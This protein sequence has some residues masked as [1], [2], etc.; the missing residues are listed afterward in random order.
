MDNRYAIETDNVTRKFGDLVAVD[1]VNLK[2]NYGEIFGL[3][4]P[5]GAGKTT[6]THMLATILCPTTGTATVVGS[7][8]CKE[9]DKVRSAIGIVFQETSLDNNLTGRENLDFHG[10]MY[11]INSE[12]RKKRISEVLEIVGLANRADSLVK[13]YSGGMKR[14]LEI[15]RGLMHHPKIL[16]LDEPTLGL[17]AQ[18]RRVVWEQV[19]KLNQTE[20]ITILLTTH[21]IEEADYLCDRVGIMDKGKILAL[22]KPRVLKDKLAG[23]VVYLKVADVEKFLKI[24]QKS[25]LVNGAKIAGERLQLPVSNGGKSIPKIIDIV[26]KNGGQVQEVSLKR[27][28]LEDVFIK[29][30]GKEIREEGPQNSSRFGPH[31]MMRR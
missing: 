31:G 3:L 28:S 14:R 6:L 19:E 1:K 22:D 13:T 21:Y 11:G 16:F 2:I 18:T 17:D 23:D 29:Y 15:A 20:K 4:G 10:R 8:I 7:D 9:P 5:N 30:T 27:P 24:F 12:Q 25:R 26:R